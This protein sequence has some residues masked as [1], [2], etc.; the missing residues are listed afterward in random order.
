[1]A[2]KDMAKL[3][4]TDGPAQI[5]LYHTPT[6]SKADSMAAVRILDDFRGQCQLLWFAF[7]GMINGRSLSLQQ[8]RQLKVSKHNKLSVGTQ[9]PEQEQSIGR[10]TFAEI[11]FVELLDAM[12]DGGEFEQ[13]N[14]KAL[15]VFIDVLWEETTRDRVADCNVPQ[16]LDSWLRCDS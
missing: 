4:W 11:S 3:Y 10:S 2:K 8:L 6:I 5:R 13:L 9:F 14:T 7:D 1:M 15:L 12:A 16:K